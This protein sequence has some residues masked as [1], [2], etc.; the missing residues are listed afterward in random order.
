MKKDRFPY[1]AY[2]LRL[3]AVKDDPGETLRASLEDPRTRETHAFP[4]L[5]ALLTYLRQEMGIE[6]E[7]PSDSL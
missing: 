5:E 7:V 4:N 6:E 2:L 1:R 3:W